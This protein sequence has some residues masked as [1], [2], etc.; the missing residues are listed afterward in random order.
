MQT[1]IRED[2]PHPD[3][4]ALDKNKQ[5]ILVAEVK[6][7]SSAFTNP[8]IRSGGIKQLL[9]FLGEINNIVPYL[10]LVDTT[11]ILIY[12]WNGNSISEPILN[13]KTVDV[14]SYYEP[15]FNQKQIF[16]LY[17]TGLIEAWISDFC[18]HW[19]SEFPPAYQELSEIGLMEKLEGGIT[20]P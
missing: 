6:A 16:S 18:Y 1:S 10:M 19:K 14:L 17:L 11:N 15:E 12:R 3:L 13:L 5:I 9:I 7:F 20:E 2:L 4:V 8:S